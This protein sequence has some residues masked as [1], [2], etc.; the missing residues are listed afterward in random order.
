MDTEEQFDLWRREYANRLLSAM[1]AVEQ[2]KMFAPDDANMAWYA[3]LSGWL[4]QEAGEVWPAEHSWP[5]TNCAE[6]YD[7]VTGKRVNG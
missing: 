1:Q 3:S 4:S 6:I 2:M 7:M 5:T